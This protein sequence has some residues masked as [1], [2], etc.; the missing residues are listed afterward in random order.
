MEYFKQIIVD[1]GKEM[2]KR[3]L[4]VATWGNLSVRDPE[5]G[6]IVVTPSG[7]DYQT[8]VP[9]DMVVFDRNGSMIE[10]KRRPSIE[11]DLHIMIYQ[12]RPDVNAIIHTH[13][14]YSTVFAV[15][16]QGIPAITEEFAQ[17][18]GYS[19]K[20]AEHA[21]P[22]TKELAEHAVRALG[23]ERAVLLASHGTVCVGPDMETVF[24]IS[25]ILEKT[26][27]ILILSKNIGTPRI[28]SKEDVKVMQDFLKTGYGQR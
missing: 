12:Q 26:A 3:S 1:A 19:V 18:V 6:Y 16:R 10:G 25:D 22:G 2:I 14:I 23:K 21:L 7:M 27:Q 4:T 17:V 20:C 8:S 15:T 9:D 28:I 13:P 5:S 24:K 11:K